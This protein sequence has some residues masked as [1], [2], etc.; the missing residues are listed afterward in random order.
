MN[1]KP[2]GRINLRETGGEPL[3]PPAVEN[4]V[5][6]WNATSS[7]ISAL[8][9]PRSGRIVSQLDRYMFLEE[10]FQAVSIKPEYDPTTYEEAMANVDSVHWVKDMKAKLESMDSNQVS[11]LIE[12]PANIKPIGYK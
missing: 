6:Q 11:V 10:A 8:V 2:K 9:L 4:N 12:V 3:D 1:H 7:P 5:R